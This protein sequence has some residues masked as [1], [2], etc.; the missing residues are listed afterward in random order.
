MQAGALDVW[1]TPCT[2]KKG[3]MGAVLHVLC[4][5][6]VKDAC[7]AI[8]L[9]E[10][11]SLGVR[12]ATVQRAALPRRTEQAVLAEGDVVRI[13]VGFAGQRTVNAHPE[14][15]DCVAVAARRSVALKHVQQEVMRVVA[16]RL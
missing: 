6:T 15:D 3:R 16:E 5:D 13:K 7:I 10:T 4:H 11:S 1:T 12:V 2:M 8:M 14:Y 9:L